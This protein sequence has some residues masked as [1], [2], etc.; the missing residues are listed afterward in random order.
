MKQ[1]TG[2]TVVV[3][4]LSGCAFSGPSVPVSPDGNSKMSVNSA[5][6]VAEVTAQYAQQQAALRL[7]TAAPREEIQL[8]LAQIV[9]RYVP[10]DYKVYVDESVDLRQSIWYDPSKAWTES[11]GGALTNAGI[12]MTANLQN[13]VMV[14]KTGTTSI[15]QAIEKYVP[16]EYL[17]F[18]DKNIDLSKR[19]KYDRSKQWTEELGKALSAIGV[20]MIA[21]LEKKVVVLKSLP[22][23]D[24]GISVAGST[25]RIQIIQQ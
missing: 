23:V 2:V 4:G 16:S 3:L 7:K 9:E 1:I 8:P 14:L 12:E 17:V 20:H 21:N 24:P 25:S 10:S 15:T 5:A 18:A 11:L 22:V 13:K 6:I 19:I